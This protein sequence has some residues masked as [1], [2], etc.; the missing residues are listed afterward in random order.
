[1][2]GVGGKLVGKD[3]ALLVG[4]GLAVDGEGIGRVIAETV[5]EAV[6]VRGHA[7]GGEG[8]Q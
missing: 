2:N 7:G 3:L 1:L 8:Y 6:G 5:E 4:N